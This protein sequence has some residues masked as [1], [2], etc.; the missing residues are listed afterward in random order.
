MAIPDDSLTSQP[1]SAP[2]AEQDGRIRLALVIPTLDQSGAEKQLSLLATGLPRDRFRVEVV[3][4]TRSG[5]LEA[6]LREAGI[7]VHVIGKRWR[8]DPFPVLRLRQW[9]REHRPDIV[10][11]WLFA[12]NSAVRMAVPS[13]S[14]I[15]VV[16]SERCVD[17]WK[18]S[19]QLW[20]DRRLARRTDHLVGNSQSVVDFYRAQGIASVPMSV[21]PNG[22]TVPADPGQTRAEF[23]ATVGIPADARVALYVGRL[24][25]QK[26]LTDLL[27]AAQLVRQKD[28]RFRFLLVGDGPERA[29]LEEHARNVEVSEFVRF[30]GHRPDAASLLHHADVFWLASDFE[31][32]SNSLMEAMACGKPCVVS[33]IPPNRELVL[34]GETGYCINPGDSV[35]FAQFTSRILEDL[36]LADRLG[37]AGRQRMAAEFRIDQMV[38]RHAALYESLVRGPVLSGQSAG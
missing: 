32:M 31:G 13:R 1:G 29:S 6:V 2:P 8:F 26:R 38:E 3:A 15:K 23:F 17:S 33:D 22:V 30:L 7:P 28:P 16:V 5:P 4:L 20:L 10:H 9:I 27:W 18:S 14:P 37:Q 34:H 36:P 19:W 35:G 11:S 25:K 24:A 21:I 12:A